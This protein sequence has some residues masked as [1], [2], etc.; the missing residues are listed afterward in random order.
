M[1]DGHTLGKLNAYDSR[2][3]LGLSVKQERY[4]PCGSNNLSATNASE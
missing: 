1:R 3:S 2:Y 4:R